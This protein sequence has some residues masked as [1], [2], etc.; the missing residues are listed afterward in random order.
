MLLIPDLS[1]LDL[2]THTFIHHLFIQCNHIRE[3]K[4]IQ[5]SCFHN[6]NASGA[7]AATTND[8]GGSL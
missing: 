2:C 6:E 7:A 3:V 5:D 4:V 8:L 1:K